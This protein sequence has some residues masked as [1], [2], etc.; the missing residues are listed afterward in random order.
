[1]ISM[2]AER[3][4]ANMK[5]TKNMEVPIASFNSANL[6]NG[7]TSSLQHLGRWNYAK[8]KFSSPISNISLDFS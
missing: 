1:M 4:S 3:K 7:F 5:A 8:L 2:I 6:P